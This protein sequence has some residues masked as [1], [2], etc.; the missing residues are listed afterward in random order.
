MG[1]IGDEGEMKMRWDD[2]VPRVRNP[3]PNP[4]P[5]RRPT[6]VFPS[7]REWTRIPVSSAGTRQRQA[8]VPW[9]A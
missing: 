4:V 9:Q 1:N 8:N 2:K 3:H 6:L 7:H 5:L